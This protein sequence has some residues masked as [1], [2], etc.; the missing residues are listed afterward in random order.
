MI[1]RRTAGGFAPTIPTLLQTFAGQAVLAI[2][3]ARLFQE[4]ARI[5]HTGLFLDSNGAVRG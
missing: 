3:N 5:S 4:L 2:E 1:R